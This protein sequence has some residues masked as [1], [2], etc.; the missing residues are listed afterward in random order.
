[1]NRKNIKFSIDKKTIIQIKSHIDNYLDY[2]EKAFLDDKISLHEV[3]DIII[4]IALLFEFIDD[5]KKESYL[6]I[7]YELAKQIKF[8]VENVPNIDISMFSGLG[9]SA[10]SI[11]LLNKKTNILKKFSKS[12]N[13]LLLDISYKKA[14]SA[15]NRNSYKT[16]DYDLINGLSGVLYYLLKFEW[17]EHKDINKII[18]IAFFLTHISDLHMYKNEY[19]PRFHVKN[20]DLDNNIYKEI[21]KN[22]SINLSLSHG[23]ISI[24]MSLCYLKNF[25]KNITIKNIDNIICSLFNIYDSFFDEHLSVFD[26]QIS[27]E[28]YV[29]KTISSDLSTR[30]SWCYGSA[31]IAIA[32]IISSHRVRNYSL[33]DK[34]NEILHRILVKNFDEFNLDEAI[35]CHGYSSIIAI[36]VGYY[37]LQNNNDDEYKVKENLEIAIK[38]TFYFLRNDSFYDDFKDLSLLEGITGIIISLSLLIN[39]DED[40]L[41]FLMLN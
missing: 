6:N 40:F 8:K 11:Y 5:G 33:Y 4:A 29:K 38:K 3:E 22:G 2:I 35:L 19:I 10:F 9:Y 13:E 20:D 28:N 39:I 21:Y 31:S 37:N 18:E 24:L 34:Y 17:H 1:M 25:S 12:L 16:E 14:T 7:A 36:I 32:L 15:F 23:A 41:H 26:T 30:E 27:L